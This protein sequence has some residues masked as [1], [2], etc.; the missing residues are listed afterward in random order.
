M[1]PAGPK[2]TLL[3][4]FGGVCYLIPKGFQRFL[5]R[6]AYRYRII[7]KVAERSELH[8]ERSPMQ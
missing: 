1:H 3:G 8:R 5:E 6:S 2:A 4:S 7:D